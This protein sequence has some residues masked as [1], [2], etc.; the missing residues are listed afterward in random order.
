MVRRK[1][2]AKEPKDGD[3]TPKDVPEGHS[4][5]L[6]CETLVQNRNPDHVHLLVDWEQDSKVKKT[7][8]KS[9]LDE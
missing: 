5:L 4:F 6:S 3:M 1:V 7:I 8:N 2:K 9:F